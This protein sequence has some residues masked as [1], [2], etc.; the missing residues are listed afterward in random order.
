MPGVPAAGHVTG[1]GAWHHGRA[2]GCLKC[3]P[4]TVRIEI[5]LRGRR[6]FS[7]VYKSDVANRSWAINQALPSLPIHWLPARVVADRDD[8]VLAERRPEEAA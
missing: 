8:K 7:D 5:T 2:D 3:Q 4:D 6:Q 1:G